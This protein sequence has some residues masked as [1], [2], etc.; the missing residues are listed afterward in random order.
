MK[1]PVYFAKGLLLV[2]L[3]GLASGCVLAP[4]EGRYDADHHRYYHE[5]AWHDCGDHDEHCR[6]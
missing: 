6:R 4:A 5:N 1:N 3:I 2:G